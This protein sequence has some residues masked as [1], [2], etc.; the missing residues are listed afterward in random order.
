MRQLKTMLRVGHLNGWS[1]ND[2][3]AG[4]KIHFEKS[5]VAI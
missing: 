3:L 4:Y 1:K 5:T 2:P